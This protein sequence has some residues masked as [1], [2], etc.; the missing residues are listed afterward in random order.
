[1]SFIKKLDVFTNILMWRKSVEDVTFFFFFL[2]KA[3]TILFLSDYFLEFY[4]A[5]S[6][7]SKPHHVKTKCFAHLNPFF[8]DLFVENR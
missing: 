5:F 3:L 8:W 6:K 7:H 2:K 1:M 4:S